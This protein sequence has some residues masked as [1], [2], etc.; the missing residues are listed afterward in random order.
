MLRL[1]CA[2][3]GGNEWTDEFSEHVRYRQGTY[4]L[5]GLGAC[6][7]EAY[8]YECPCGESVW[9]GYWDCNWVEIIDGYVY[10]CATCGL[11][12]TTT[13]VNGEAIDDCHW[14]PL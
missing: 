12:R 2:D 9:V 1:P 3:C 7:T 5:S 11:M 10:Q 8:L 14:K 13:W 6:G 4:D